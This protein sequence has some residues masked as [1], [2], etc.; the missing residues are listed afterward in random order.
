MSESPESLGR[1]SVSVL[2]N[3][4]AEEV[5]QI[6][7][8][9]RSTFDWEVSD[10]D[11]EELSE[12]L[13]NPDNVV[14]VIRSAQKETVGYIL[15]IPTTATDASLVENDQQFTPR[16]TDLYIE[17]FAIAP[18]HRVLHTSGVIKALT[19]EAMRRGYTKV[20]AHVPVEHVRLYE[21]FGAKAVRTIDEWYDS[22]EP[23]VFIEY[24]L[25]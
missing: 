22:S 10:D 15:A 24:P 12:S 7:N 16:S 3:P 9:E 19:D 8:L 5:E 18:P 13:Q 20:V 21:A 14:A 6:V 4:S 25:A 17:T 1:P 23:H 2:E 11:M